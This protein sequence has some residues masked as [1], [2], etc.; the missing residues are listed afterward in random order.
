MKKSLVR[1][2]PRSTSKRKAQLPTENKTI[3][4]VPLYNL[5]IDG[6]SSFVSLTNLVLGFASP[7]RLKL[8][9]LPQATL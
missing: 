2:V 3:P 6:T 7:S 9:A 4:V 8:S 1:D 5:F